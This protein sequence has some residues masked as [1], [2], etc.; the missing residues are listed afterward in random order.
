MKRIRRIVDGFITIY[1]M[2]SLILKISVF[3]VRFRIH[4]F[5]VRRRN[6]SRL[7]KTLIKH[8]LPDELADKLATIYDETL[9]SLKGS[10]NIRNIFTGRKHPLMEDSE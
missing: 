2:I 7:R 6:R 9:D 8:N 5:L 3:I 1:Y 10:T 4:L